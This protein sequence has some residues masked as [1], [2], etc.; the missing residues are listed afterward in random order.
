[1]RISVSFYG[2]IDEPCSDGIPPAVFLLQHVDTWTF[3]VGFG[4]FLA[5]YSGYMLFRPAA[6]LSRVGSRLQ[7]AAIGFAGGLV[8]GPTAMPG[9][10]PTIWCDLR[11]IPKEQQRGLVQPFI[12]VMQLFALA[13][14]LLHHTLTTKLLMDATFSLPALAAGTAAG[15]ILFGRI[16]DAAFRRAILAVLLVAGLALVA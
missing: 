14:M 16:D 10:V 4:C 11:G 7:D 1:V 2:I 12:T 5:L 15:I 8:G 9:A 6:Y 3:R 13:L